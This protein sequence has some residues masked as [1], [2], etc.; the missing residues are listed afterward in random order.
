MQQSSPTF[1]NQMHR[2]IATEV[3]RLNYRQPGGPEGWRLRRVITRGYWLT[4]QDEFHVPHGRLLFNG[5]NGS[6]KSVLLGAALPF[7]LDNDKRPHRLST[8]R[9]DRSRSMRYFVI[10]GAKDDVYHPSYRYEARTVY[11][12]LEW[13]WFGNEPPE[14]LRETW[15]DG[16]PV[17][18]LT[19]GVGLSA[20]ERTDQ[21]DSWGFVV[22]DGRRFGID[23]EVLDTRTGQGLSY[24]A[25]RASLKDG[26]VATQ[27]PRKYKEMVNR[28]LFG[29]TDL[30]E[31][32]ALLDTLLQLRSSKLGGDMKPSTVTE[33]LSRSLPELPA[34]KTEQLARII[35]D[36]DDTERELASIREAIGI[37]REVHAGTS[38]VHEARTRLDA[39]DLTLADRE[40]RRAR[41]EEERAQQEVQRLQGELEETSGKLSESQRELASVQEQVRQ[42]QEL[43]AN[44]FSQEDVLQQRQEERDRQSERARRA[45]EDQQEAVR[46]LEGTR[47][48]LRQL[49]QDFR[50][51]RETFEHRA[52]E[53]HQ[54]ARNASWPA[55]ARHAQSLLGLMPRLVL[56]DAASTDFGPGTDAY[57][58]EIPDATA[59]VT[60]GHQRQM[61]LSEA[62]RLARAASTLQTR[63]EAAQEAVQ[64]A[65]RAVELAEDAARQAEHT[66]R[67]AREGAAAAV[68]AWAESCEALMVPV[69]P[70]TEVE[71]ALEHAT[72]EPDVHALLRPLEQMYH[73]QRDETE[74]L[75]RAADMHVRS[76]NE[77]IKEVAAERERKAAEK[78]ATPTRSPAVEAAR[79]A[80]QAAG[81][82][83]VP[84]Y[85][86][87][88][89]QEGT[90]AALQ[91]SV[92]AFLER[93]GLLDA[94]VVDPA[95][96]GQ[97]LNLL[98]EQGLAD[99]LLEAGPDSEA[100]GF[101][102]AAPEPC[103]AA[104]GA[105][106]HP[107]SRNLGNVLCPE[108][109]APPG[110]ADLLAAIRLAEGP[111]GETQ[112]AYNVMAENP[113]SVTPWSPAAWSPT[114]WT[115][116]LL[117]GTNEP[118]AIAQFI[119]AANRRRKRERE[120]T[121][122]DARLRELQ[123]EQEQARAKH[124]R[125]KELMA[126]LAAEWN[127]V[128][129]LSQWTFLRGALDERQ[130]AF[131]RRKEARATLETAFTDAEARHKAWKEAAQ[132]LEQSLAALLGPGTAPTEDEI[133]DLQQETGH[134]LAVLERSLPP[135]QETL[136][137]SQS[138]WLDLL[139]QEENQGTHCERARQHQEAE[140][141][142]EAALA[143][144]VQELEQFLE[145]AGN[146]EIRARYRNLQ[147]R[148]PE[149]EQAVKQYS[150]DKIGTEKQLPLVRQQWTEKQET[151]DRTQAALDEAVNQFR[152]SLYAYPIFTQERP[153]EGA[154]ASDL[155]ALALNL[156]PHDLPEGAARRRTLEEAVNSR[157]MD[158]GDLLTRHDES[159]SKRAH[160]NMY[161]GDPHYVKFFV[162]HIAYHPFELVEHL[163][164]EA[165]N[166]QERLNQAH[167]KLLEDF[168]LRELADDI[169]MLIRNGYDWERRI[170][171]VLQH[172][173]LAET[174]FRLDWR[175]VAGTSL[176]GAEIAACH[177]LL[178]R[179]ADLLEDHER[180]R[181]LDAFQHEINRVRDL[182]R[183]GLLEGDFARKMKDVLDYRNWFRFVIQQRVGERIR[184][185]TD[186]N[187][188]P[189]SGGERALSLI[190]P[191]VAAVHARYEA[192]APGAPRLIALDEAFAG[193]DPG[194][195]REAYALLVSLGFNWIMTSEK[196][197]AI[198]DALPAAITYTLEAPKGTDEFY[199]TPILWNGQQRIDVVAVPD[200]LSE[201]AATKEPSTDEIS[202]DQATDGEAVSE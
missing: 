9:G 11:F 184:D 188:A 133:D 189:G 129:H 201:V 52:Q 35:S 107:G 5:H 40:A 7:A 21:V 142:Q 101:A 93:A 85:A 60:Q 169:G 16:S 124:A 34:E 86:A 97:A 43:H 143:A 89:F 153:P 104:P 131:R 48:S 139:V 36:L 110:L 109:E 111:D 12:A 136:K 155:A 175:P 79:Q 14:A 118:T 102:L 45:R 54:H 59:L 167:R 112:D 106:G 25:L 147:Q 63:Y 130:Q 75:D 47:R 137:S 128:L 20:S 148:L 200:A 146:R 96:R 42:M 166:Q 103:T 67:E 56:A 163:E 171:Q 132:A 178:L 120:L 49:E 114:S 29:F 195:I 144:A 100:L 181:L 41:R 72:D 70:L 58:T 13:E 151:R 152:E 55:A 108:S 193:V 17:R 179:D 22:L 92:E 192:A 10:G 190:V 140:E 191:L 2:Y 74:G 116:G 26:G 197:L 176:P 73:G 71:Q 165:E 61:G 138:R 95:Q 8:F 81:I 23:F 199:Y 115:H 154:D 33:L 170:N 196:L 202:T 68:Q 51:S 6:G 31:Y 119:G 127:R 90:D 187:F 141:Q 113:D 65:T 177:K 122:L 149:L 84:L 164:H 135:C 39:Y 83:A 62:R 78:E 64:Q 117:R 145:K 194:N 27:E 182:N 24:A 82:A 134:A 80:L 69:G 15:L 125:M 1:F 172:A 186:A 158:L 185:L 66:W 19:T 38:A 87:C 46:T 30:T 50:H 4:G 180:E 123:A 168:V 121:E 77:V 173:T 161:P 157:R 18:F 3:D 183:Q 162:H 198:S 37:S 53:L 150:G 105:Q 44:L 174:Q 94:L 98:R 159:L 76:L 88:D 28:Y 126:A 99:A 160:R 91:G 156:L 57:T 32:Q